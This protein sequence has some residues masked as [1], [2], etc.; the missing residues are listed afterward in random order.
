VHVLR[1]DDPPTLG[2]AAA[3]LI[4]RIIQ[5]TIA[6]ARQDDGDEEGDT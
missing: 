1:P 3:V 5:R 6:S 2:P 4:A